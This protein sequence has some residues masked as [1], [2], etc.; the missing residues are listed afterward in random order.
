MYHDPCLQ[1]RNRLDSIYVSRA[2]A[3]R[4]SRLKAMEERARKGLLSEE[5]KDILAAELAGDKPGKG[6][7]IIG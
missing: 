7:C 3:E 5:E 1:L 6:D 2:K 4:E